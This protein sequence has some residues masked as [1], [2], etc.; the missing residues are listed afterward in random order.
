VLDDGK[1]ELDA[2]VNRDVIRGYQSLHAFLLNNNGTT[3][4]PFASLTRSW[5]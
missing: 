1:V 2:I 4:V 3:S 5:A